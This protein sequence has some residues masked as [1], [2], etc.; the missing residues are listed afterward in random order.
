MYV[1]IVSP[2]NSL[3]DL[4]TWADANTGR[5]ANDNKMDRIQLGLSVS[6]YEASGHEVFKAMTN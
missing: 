3:A 5:M 1:A 6:T 2:A 4:F